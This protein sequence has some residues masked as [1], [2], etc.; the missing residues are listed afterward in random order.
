MKSLLFVYLLILV[1]ALFFPGCVVALPSA[2]HVPNALPNGEVR[3]GAAGGY[4]NVSTDEPGI[5]QEYD[6]GQVDAWIDIGLS[7]QRELRVHLVFLH[8]ITE[9]DLSKTRCLPGFVVEGKF[10]NPSGNMALIIG[11]SFMQILTQ[12]Q[13]P[14]RDE[15]EANMPLLSLYAGGVF[16]LGETGRPR[17]VV[18][19]RVASLWPYFQVSLALGLDLPITRRISIRPEGHV[20]CAFIWEHLSSYDP[21]FISGFGLA[22]VF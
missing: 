14:W 5:D 1:L 7:K 9:E 10:S 18:L 20:T 13:E 6:F 2:Y 4:V 16:A 3:F 22:V 21:S 15:F 8:E 19:P 17:L 11:L 12:H